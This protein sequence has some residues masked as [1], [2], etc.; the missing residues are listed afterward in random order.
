M[1]CFCEGVPFLW[2]LCMFNSLGWWHP[3]IPLGLYPVLILGIILHYLSIH[4]SLTLSPQIFDIRIMHQ[5]VCISGT[6][7]HPHSILDHIFPV[8]N[9]CCLCFCW[10]PNN[11]I[12]QE[13]PV[14][15]RL[16][17]PGLFKYDRRTQ[18]PNKEETQ[19]RWYQCWHIASIGNSWDRGSTSFFAPGC[20]WY[21]AL[22]WKL[23]V[24]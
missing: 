20:Q 18:T 12:W 21:L 4:H 19:W 14:Y 9:M 10:V 1:L 22:L 23:Y 16:S 15:Y 3:L 5:L 7:G 8:L 13:A 2:S 11:I 6:L 24:A 17:L